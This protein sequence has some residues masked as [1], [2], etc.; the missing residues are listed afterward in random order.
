MKRFLLSYNSK[1]NIIHILLPYKHLF[2]LKDILPLLGISN[3]TVVND[4]FG[5][6]E[7]VG[8]ISGCE[9]VPIVENGNKNLFNLLFL[10]GSIRTLTSDCE[11]QLLLDGAIRFFIDVN[12]EEKEVHILIDAK[13]YVALLKQLKSLQA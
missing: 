7:T 5:K 2:M 8:E 1:R 11:V 9:I 10:D 6:Y 13:R 3:V 4:C 12:Y